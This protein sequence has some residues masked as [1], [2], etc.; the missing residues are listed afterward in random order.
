MP[1]A[2]KIIINIRE[3]ESEPWGVDPFKSKTK[4]AKKKQMVNQPPVWNLTGI[5]YNE[6]SPI[7]YINK[8]AVRV[9]S[10]IN[11]AQVIDISRS[12][13]TLE[14]KGNRFTLHVGKG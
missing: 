1:S 6:Q 10:M 7:A 5:M 11:E 14:L 2:D 8:K 13:V 3:K 12:A 9:G 4:R